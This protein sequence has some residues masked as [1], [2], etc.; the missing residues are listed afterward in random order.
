MALQTRPPEGSFSQIDPGGKKKF[1]V[2]I[3]N[4]FPCPVS[5]AIMARFKAKLNWAV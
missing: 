3:K 1:F 2:N 5:G 4:L